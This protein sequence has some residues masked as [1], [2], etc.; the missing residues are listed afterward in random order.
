MKGGV[1]SDGE[2]QP[3]LFP[4]S[5]LARLDPEVDDQAVG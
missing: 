2:D 1:R 3:R 4:P 5:A